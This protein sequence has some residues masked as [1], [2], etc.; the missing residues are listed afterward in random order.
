MV[1][2]KG[3]EGKYSITK[4]GKVFSHIR[5]KF[6]KYDLRNNYYAVKLGKYGK[7]IAVHRLVALTYIENVEDKPYINHIDGNKLNNNVDNLEWCTAK[8]NI[9][10]AQ[11]NGLMKVKT[12]PVFRRQKIS[13]EEAIK[14]CEAFK[15]GYSVLKLAKEYNVIRGTIYAILKKNKVDRRHY[16]IQ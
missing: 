12:Y 14:I 15:N 6:L 11:M 9:N 3:Y 7:K 1:F 8:E 13:N 5:N 16:V 2:I 10:H 4:D